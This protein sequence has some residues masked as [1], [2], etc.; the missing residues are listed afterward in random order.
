MIRI[1]FLIVI[2]VFIIQINKSFSKGK[3]DPEPEQKP[4][5][6]ESNKTII[7]SEFSKSETPPAA[8]GYEIK[9]I[10][11]RSGSN[12]ARL[13]NKTLEECAEE[14]DKNVDCR[15]F[16]YNATGKT[17][18]RKFS[19]PLGD[20]NTND[21]HQYYDRIDQNTCISNDNSVFC[22]R[23]LTSEDGKY[24]FKVLDDGTLTITNNQTGD[25][26]WTRSPHRTN[27]TG[28]PRLLMQVQ[29]N[30]VV[31]DD[32]GVLWATSNGYDDHLDKMPYKFVM[33]NN[34][35][36]QVI[37]KNGVAVVDS[38]SYIDDSADTCRQGIC[39]FKLTSADGKYTF[40]VLDNGK[41]T[42]TDNKS[43]NVTWAREP[44]PVTISPPLRLAL[45]EHGNL[46]LY[47]ANNAVVWATGGEVS[48]WNNDNGS[49]RPYTLKIHNDGRL[50][51]HSANG[52]PIIDIT[53]LP[54][55]PATIQTTDWDPSGWQW[56]AA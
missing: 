28:V 9:G 3:D 54:P 51:T 33:T 20:Y 31:Y 37:D 45:Q 47:D 16:G 35:N 39:P 43:G 50:F 6:E 32:N 12:M 14:C 24:T 7:V 34:G 49:G 1:V 53:N 55:P 23:R 25:V 18:F 17:C 41:L 5:P 29:G 40:K 13:D 44:N 26:K 4:T 30:A 36:F 2:L 52:T 8:P 46:V 27:V 11:D 56:N 21:P 48:G 22:P 15:G 42:I 19:G 38:N 10:G